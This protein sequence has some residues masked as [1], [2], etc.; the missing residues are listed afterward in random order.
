VN[1]P[2]HALEYLLATAGSDKDHPRDAPI[3]TKFYTALVVGAS[4]RRTQEE[5]APMSSRS[6][7]ALASLVLTG[8]GLVVLLP[9]YAS[10]C[11]C[12]GGSSKE[13]IVD[14]SLSHPGAVVSGEVVDVEKGSFSSSV[15]LRVFEVWKGP[16][17]ETLELSTPNDG[18]A[19]GYPFKEGQEYLVYAYWGNQG[20]PPRPGLK[21]DLCSQTK[22]LSSAGEDLA[23]LEKL[24]NG[25][26]PKNSDALNDTSGGVPARAMVWMTGLAMAASFLLVVRL[27]R[28]G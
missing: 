26:K 13:E 18:A 12:G 15:T 19:C 14:W 21:V 10:A 23:L 3:S 24:G 1:K 11:S 5:P 28:T 7:A 20:T 22:P 8:L 4:D 25:E 16:Q 6:L 2:T 9:D 27:V 17:R